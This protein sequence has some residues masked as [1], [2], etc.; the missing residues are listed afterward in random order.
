[1]VNFGGQTK[2]SRFLTF[3][4]FVQCRPWLRTVVDTGFGRPRE[5]TLTEDFVGYRLIFD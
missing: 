3:M 2:P 5:V 4:A 1:M